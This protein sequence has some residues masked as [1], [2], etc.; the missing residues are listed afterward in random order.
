[1]RGSKDSLYEGGT[2][3]AVDCALARGTFRPAGWMKQRSCTASISFP[4]FCKLSGTSLPSGAFDGEDMSANFFGKSVQ[5][6][7]PL[8]WEY[9]RNE[10]FGYPKEYPGQRSPNVAV[11]DGDWKLLVNAD[12][13]NLELYNLPN[14]QL[15]T[16]NVAAKNPAIAKRLSAAA[17]A[18]R[19][20][21]Q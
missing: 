13:S 6:G 15:E 8:F 18:W 9:G 19:K 10:T 4:I 11:R 17:L 14:D 1:M 20:S 7:H 16:N 3:D 12:G 21:V 5:R 2:R